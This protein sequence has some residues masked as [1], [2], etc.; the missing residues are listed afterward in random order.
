[1][2]SEQTIGDKTKAGFGDFVSGAR[3]EIAKVTWPTR[4]E[5]MLTTTLIV[6]FAIVSGVFF[7]LVDGALSVAISHLLGMN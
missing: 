1:M 7:M 5:V 6:V 3:R 2:A 4:K